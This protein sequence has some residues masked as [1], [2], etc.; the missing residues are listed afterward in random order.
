MFSKMLPLVLA[1]VLFAVPAF[2]RS[3]FMPSVGTQRIAATKSSIATQLNAKYQGAGYKAGDVKI[4]TKLLQQ[5]RGLYSV[6][7]RTGTYKTPYDLAH[8]ESGAHGKF[9]STT[10]M[11]AGGSVTTVKILKPIQLLR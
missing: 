6:E 3:P 1:A 2:A 7:K 9:I 5:S 8:H 10:K 4:R 11:N